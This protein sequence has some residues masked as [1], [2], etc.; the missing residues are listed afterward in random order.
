[1]KVNDFALDGTA[2]TP[3][4]LCYQKVMPQRH[5]LLCNAMILTDNAMIMIRLYVK[6]L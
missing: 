4:E 5:F 6:D 2:C 3:V 1:M